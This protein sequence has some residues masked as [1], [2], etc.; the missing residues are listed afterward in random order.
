MG[1]VRKVSRIGKGGR[2]NTTAYGKKNKKKHNKDKYAVQMSNIRERWNK[3]I[4]VRNNLKDLGLVYDINSD[5]GRKNKKRNEIE[6]METEEAIRNNGENQQEN[7]P[8]A[9]DKV[10]LKS[11]AKALRDEFT[12][13]SQRP[14]RKTYH[15]S[16]AETEYVLNLLKKHGTDY[17][18]M[19]KDKLNYDQLTE[20]QLR[21][22]CEELLCSTEPRHLKKLKEFDLAY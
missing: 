12:T 4:S 13:R 14:V 10:R 11:K 5:I 8:M 18:K 17:K 19:F 1:R 15:L 3:K 20:N 22:K 2:I 7:E 6:F 9:T 21:K 16:S